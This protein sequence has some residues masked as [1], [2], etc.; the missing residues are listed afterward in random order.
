VKKNPNPNV[1]LALTALVVL[2]GG[3]GSLYQYQSLS[4]QG[5]ALEELRAKVRD[6]SGIQAELDSASRKLEECADKLAHLEKGVP[7]LAYVPTL[8][9]ELERVGADKGIEVLGVRPVPKNEPAD[10][11]KSRRDAY[12]ELDIEVRGRG[13]YR[14]VMNFISALERFPKV[15]AVRTISLS[16]KTDV[17]GG[18]TLDVVIEL[19]SYLFPAAT[20]DLTKTSAQGQGV[21]H[22]G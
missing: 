10:G 21:Q 1:F 19:R 8:L 4:S 6:E 17:A 12:Q 18:E 3:A 14:A 20:A 22:E 11:K 5:K 15:V 2:A 13:R 7:E 9:A 16:P